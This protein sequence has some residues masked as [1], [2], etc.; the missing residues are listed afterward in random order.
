MATP[1]LVSVKL[2]RNYGAR[3]IHRS[4]RGVRRRFE[5]PNGFLSIQ[6]TAMLLGTYNN[7]VRRMIRSGRLEAVKRPGSRRI[8]LASVRVLMREPAA[9]RLTAANEG[10]RP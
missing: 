7:M 2:L 8:V 6:E 1:K 4:T 5:R 9:R 10:A 3:V